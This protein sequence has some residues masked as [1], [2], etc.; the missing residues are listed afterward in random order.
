MSS[1]L[2]PSYFDDVYRRSSDPWEMATSPYEAEKYART[3][4]ALPRERYRSGLEIGCSVGV[5]SSMIAPRC[6]SFLGVDVSENALGHARERCRSIAHA[7]FQRWEIPASF[8]PAKFD[9]VLLSEVGYYWSREDL[10]KAQDEIVD[11]LEGD[12]T[13]LLVHWTP[14][15]P[16]YP[17]TGDEV[18]ESFLKRPEFLH[19]HGGRRE[20][21][22]L[23]LFLRRF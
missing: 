2:K 14:F 12:G 16:D 9:L 5:L 1:S 22:R 4:A 17:L 23:D 21:Y 19:V 7:E 3:L 6:E 15:V 18:H 13:L 20:K 10:A 11:H 8:P